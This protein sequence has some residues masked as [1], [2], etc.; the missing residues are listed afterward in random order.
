MRGSLLTL[1]VIF[2]DI[3][4]SSEAYYN[5]DD[6]KTD[7]NPIEYGHTKSFF[8]FSFVSLSCPQAALISIP[9]E[10]RMVQRSP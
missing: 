9:F 8:S 3:D 1:S 4:D 7:L 6:Q 2:N 5:Y 10:S